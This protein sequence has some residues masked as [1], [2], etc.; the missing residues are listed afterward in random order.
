MKAFV[1]EG[2]ASQASRD[3]HWDCGYSDVTLGYVLSK[4]NLSLSSSRSA[5]RCATRRTAR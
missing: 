5:T 1:A 4:S 3:A 2:R